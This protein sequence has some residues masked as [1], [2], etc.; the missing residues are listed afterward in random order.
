MK[1]FRNTELK[2][3]IK[4]YATIFHGLILAFTLFT[5]TIINEYEWGLTFWIF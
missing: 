5:L 3:N 2:E 1:K 4:Q